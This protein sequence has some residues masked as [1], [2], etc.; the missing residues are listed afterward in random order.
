MFNADTTSLHSGLSD[1]YYKPI[2]AHPLPDAELA[3]LESRDQRLKYRIRVLRLISRVVAAILSAT[4]LAPLAMTIIKFLQTRNVYYEVD[5]KQRTA[6]ANDTITWYTYM[7]FGVAL[8]SFV[9]NAAI[10]IAYWKGVKQANSAD[11]VAGWWSHLIM[12]FHIVVWGVSA[13]LYRYG[14]EPVNGKFRDLWGWTCSTAAEEL[15]PI[16]TDVKFALY[17]NVQ[18]CPPFFIHLDVASGC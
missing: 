6:W 2:A 15:Q 17:C 10:L 11:K 8:V 14:K 7:Y 4:T 3:R 18:V 1:E 16:V 13:G 9:F 5:G 12:V